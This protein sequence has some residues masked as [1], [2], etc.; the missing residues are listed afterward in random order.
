MSGVIHKAGLFGML[1][2]ILMV[3]NKDRAGSD[4]G[5][6]SGWAGICWRC[7]PCRRSW[8]C[9]HNLAT[10]PQRLLGYSSTENVGIAGMGFG[11][12]CVGLALEQPV[13]VALGFGGGILH[14]L[15]HALFK[16]LLFYGAGAVYR[17]THTIDLEKLG[18]CSR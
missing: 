8:V 7:R 6:T 1:K 2:F 9:V 13:L 4:G 15:N 14:I 3:F 18:A 11:M 10:G 17:F 12:G 5:R 16:C